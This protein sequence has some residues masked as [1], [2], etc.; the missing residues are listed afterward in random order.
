MRNR[1]L[2]QGQHLAALSSP[3]IIPGALIPRP[4]HPPHRRYELRLHDGPAPWSRSSAS[5]MASVFETDE[6]A[7]TTLAM[8]RAALTAR[9]HDTYG[10]CL[11]GFLLFC[12]EQGIDPLEVTP[13]LR[14]G[15]TGAGWA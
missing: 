13:P 4:R 12:D 15:R 3:G 5:S 1:E 8:F 9:S 14:S 10:S 7:K 6:L 11:R 2:H